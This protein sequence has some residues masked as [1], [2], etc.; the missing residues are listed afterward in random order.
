M[1]FMPSAAAISASTALLLSGCERNRD[2]PWRKALDEGNVIKLGGTVGKLTPGADSANAPLFPAPVVVQPSAGGT[3]TVKK[4]PVDDLPIPS[5]PKAVEKK[6]IAPD[7][8][9]EPKLGPPR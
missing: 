2:Q 1:R 7:K 3:P 5:P 9:D 8:D 6:P 4:A